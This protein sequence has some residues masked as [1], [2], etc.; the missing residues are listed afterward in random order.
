M[1]L[2]I[3]IAL[4][5]SQAVSAS[6]VLSVTEIAP[7]V[8]MHT[9]PRELVDNKNHG[10]IANIGFIVGGRCVAVI[11]TGG[12]PEQG[13]ALKNAI[14]HVTNK[15]V[16]YVI[17]THVHPDHLYGNIAFKNTGAQFVGHHKLAASL[18]S[19]GQY[20]LDKAPEQLG[21]QLAASELVP[22]TLEVE[23]QLEIDLGDRV[24]KLTAHP[25]A[26]TDNDLSVLDVQTDTLWLSDLLFIS[27][28]PTLDG[29]VK[30]WL[31][32][33]EKLEQH[34]YQRVV[35][36]HG[37][38]VTDWPKGMQAEKRYLST[39]LNDV[40]NLIKAGKYLEEALATAGYSE[41]GQ[42]ELFEQFHRKNISLAFA[43]LEW[44]D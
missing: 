25:P 11:D 16:C 8:Y 15:P 28:V 39:L 21:V 1:R 18:S 43:E 23:E 6:P 22:P 32:E 7:G 26:H 19:R 17:N 12:N 42:W 3:L 27:H 9:G 34:R 2:L 35:P 41:Q 30:G 40:R 37:P 5:L 31:A 33:L 20:Y 14:R 10:A 4:L 24:L 36:G 38:V 44:E 29:S 13:Q